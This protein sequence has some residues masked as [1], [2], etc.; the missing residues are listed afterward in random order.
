MAGAGAGGASGGAGAA[1]AAC[2]AGAA[3]M[4]GGG[5]GGGSTVGDGAVWWTTVFDG[6][7]I[8]GAD[9]RPARGGRI[10]IGRG[11]AVGRSDTVSFAVGAGCF[12]DTTDS[13]DL[14]GGAVFTAAGLGAGCLVSVTLAGATTTT[15]DSCFSSLSRR[16][17]GVSTSSLIFAV[18]SL[19]SISSRR[20]RRA[21][22]VSS[23]IE[24]ECVFFSLT[25]SSGSMSRITPGLTSSSLASSLMRIFFISRTPVQLSALT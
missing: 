18:L 17:G 7:G 3:G 1:G 6:M 4:G 23:S 20:R 10:G 14:G 9:P 25:P 2:C 5:G 16:A 21:I 12:G 8:D 22:D 24:L 11:G 19:D 15:P 13:T